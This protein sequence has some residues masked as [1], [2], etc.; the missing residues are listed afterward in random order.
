MGDSS[1][2]F[3]NGV[4]FALLTRSVR[5]R[6]IH[7]LLKVFCCCHCSLCKKKEDHGLHE[8][9]HDPNASP[10]FSYKSRR[11]NSLTDTVSLRVDTDSNSKRPY[12]TSLSNFSADN[13]PF[14]LLDSKN[15]QADIPYGSFEDKNAPNLEH[16]HL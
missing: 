10:S 11:T 5:Y 7:L 3:M 15:F 14:G 4:L 13:M 12:S 2:G 16:M 1:Q 8:T 6:L 9:E